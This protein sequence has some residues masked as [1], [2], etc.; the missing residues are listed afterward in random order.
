LIALYPNELQVKIQEEARVVEILMTSH[1]Q[2]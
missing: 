2:E 1:A